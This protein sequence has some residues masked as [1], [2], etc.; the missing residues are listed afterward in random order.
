MSNSD[1]PEL[2]R[3]ASRQT[4]GSS[5]STALSPVYEERLIVLAQG[6]QFQNANLN[7]YA[8]PDYLQSKLGADIVVQDAN[9][10]TYCS[11]A[12]HV[13]FTITKVTTK[14][15]LKTALE[16]PN[17]HV[18]Y[19]GHARHGQG[20]CFGDNTD[21]GEDWGNGSDP[22]NTGLYRC[23][24]PFVSLPVN[25]ILEHRYTVSAV[26]GDDDKPARDDCHP[27][28]KSHYGSLRKFAVSDLAGGAVLPY[29]GSGVDASSTFWAFDGSVDGSNGR[30]LVTNSG[31]TGTATDPYDLGATN[32][33]CR[34]FAC[35]GCSTFVHN[36]PIVRH[37][38]NWTHTDD[39]R[40]A[41]WTT[42]V[43]YSGPMA[44][45]WL[46]RILSY[47]TRND[48]ENW[49]GSLEASV[50]RTNADYVAFGPDISSSLY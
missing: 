47:P 11:D 31:W 42:H 49:K 39:D 13:N 28:I 22:A 20:P 35:I 17:V 16:T 37:R 21:P 41:Y 45:F 1:L 48:F 32:L 23:G 5:G 24:F 43:T 50:R 6:I 15:E 4:A 33:Q 29:L 2:L 18:V 46:H 3:Q 27:E 44:A 36:Y 9:T 19:C 7:I 14:T 40:F 34:V 25:E 38:K 12:Q 26:S 8:F 10:I 30:H